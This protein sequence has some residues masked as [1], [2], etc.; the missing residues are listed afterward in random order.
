MSLQSPAADFIDVAGLIRSLSDRE[1]IDAADAYFASLSIDS[2]QCRKP[3]YATDGLPH[4]FQQ[5]GLVFEAAD[6]F[7]ACDVLDFGCG[8]GWLGI[9]LA[10]AGCIATGVDVARSALRL[11]EE[12]AASRKFANSGKAAFAHY[13]GRVLPF[14]DASF[15]RIV[16][17]DAFHHVTNQR[18]T[19]A[20]LARVLRPG[21]R[22]AF[23]EPG[24]NHSKTPQSQAEMAAHKVIENDIRMQD[25]VAYARD[26]GLSEPK[27]LLGWMRAPEV[28]A[29]EFMAWAAKGISREGA[30][31]LMAPMQRHL[32]DRQ[33]FYMTKGV[34]GSD[35]RRSGS[36]GGQVHVV[37]AV[38]KGA[39]IEVELEV[40]NTGAG[41]WI[42]KAEAVGVVHVGVQWRGPGRLEKNFHRIVIGGAAVPPGEQRRV[43]GRIPAPPPEATELAFDLVAEWVAWFSDLGACVPAK[44]ALPGKA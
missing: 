31:R 28:T 2:P 43:L 42:T 7:P 38:R 37:G 26:C 36:L 13:D 16:S 24:P 19:I 9:G 4:I 1:L 10:D 15:D 6:L 40:R 11:A 34:A 22:M 27:M 14:E 12:L 17:F 25:I 30:G 20:E 39:A 18:A 44:V 33:C 5:L 21:G 29:S 41:T 32:T 35:S 8:T 23:L 3:F